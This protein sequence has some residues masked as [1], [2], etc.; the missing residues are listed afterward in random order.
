[1]RQTAPLRTLRCA[2]SRSVFAGCRRSLLVDGPS[3]HYPRTPCTGAWTHTPPSPAGALTHF[4]PEGVGLAPRETRSANGIIPAMQFQQGAVFRGCSHS[5]RFRLLRSLGPQVAPTAACAGR[6]G[7][8]HHALPR[9]IACSECGIATCPTW[10]IDTTGLSPV[11]S[12]SCRLLLPASGSSATRTR[13]AT[14]PVVIHDDRGWQGEALHYDTFEALPRHARLRGAA[15]KPRPP[16]PQDLVPET[17]QRCTVAEDSVVVV[18][19]T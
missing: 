1:M 13:C 15:I 4:F 14:A 19:P 3:R 18:V 6:P 16:D 17:G 11:G 10:A 8:L 5:L 2:L 9:A 7:R 12:R